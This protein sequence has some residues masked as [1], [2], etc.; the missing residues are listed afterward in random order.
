MTDL[1]QY[2]AYSG[3][4]I[5]RMAP[6]VNYVRWFGYIAHLFVLLAIGREGIFFLPIK[7]A[8]TGGGG[9]GGGGAQYFR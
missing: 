4:Y 6:P 2:F 9:G 7:M 8:P 5:G 1:V 3:A